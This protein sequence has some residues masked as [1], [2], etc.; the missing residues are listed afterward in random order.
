MKIPLIVF[1]RAI[2]LYLLFTL[3]AL[4]LPFMYVYSAFLATAFGS[5]AGV[6]FVACYMIVA[7]YN[8]SYQA[9]MTIL[10]A[11]VP[12]GVAASYMLI[13]WF[14]A[15][16]DLWGVSLFLVFPVVAVIAGWASLFMSRKKIRAQINAE[17]DEL[18]LLLNQ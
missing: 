10:A 3:P 18:Q 9:K 6:L 17:A 4:V 5:A 2:A 8:I 16:D 1:A 13:G 12:I 7:D 11:I 15:V 14:D